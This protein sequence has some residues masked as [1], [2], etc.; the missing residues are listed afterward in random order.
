[1]APLRL[2]WGWRNPDDEEGREGDTIKRTVGTVQIEQVLKVQG[3]K[4]VVE[5][6]ALHR[7]PLWC[8]RSKLMIF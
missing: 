5:H 8:E 6:T 4:A 1:M 7:W 2:H 3:K